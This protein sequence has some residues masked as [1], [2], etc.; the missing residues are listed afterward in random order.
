MRVR[1]EAELG[2]FVSKPL[3]GAYLWVTTSDTWV[4]NNRQK[5]KQ[6]RKILG[7]EKGLQAGNGRELQ[8]ANS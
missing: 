4:Q 5:R 1:K 3:R 2:Y 7:D 8:K 6:K